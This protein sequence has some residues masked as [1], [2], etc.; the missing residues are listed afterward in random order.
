MHILVNASNLKQ[1]G[2][3][4]VA[5]SICRLLGRFPQ[6]S[7]VA[8]ISNAMQAIRSDLEGLQNVSVKVYDIRNTISSVFFH[9]DT[10]LDTLVEK[11][12]IDAVLTVFGP[13]RWHPSVP[14]LSGFARAQ[15]LP[16]DTPYFDSVTI[17]DRILNFFVKRS[18][19]A[20]SD[21][22]WTEN[23]A[24]SDLLLKV[25]P[26]KRV[27]TVSNNYNQ[28]FDS[29]ER[30]KMRTLPQFRG[31]T[32]LTVTNAYPH[33][34]LTIAVKVAEVLRERYPD[35]NFRFVFTIEREEFPGMDESLSRHFFFLGKVG[36]EECP[37]LY[38][39][40]DIMFQPTLLE[41][42]SATYPEAMR[43]NVPILT[44]DLSFARGLCGDAALYFSPLSADDAADNIYE[45]A[46][47]LD[48]RNRLISS[49]RERLES[50]KNSEQRVDDLISIV[51]SLA[52]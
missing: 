20:C 22:Y 41:S 31:S 8:V 43:M 2:G 14:H 15:I 26:K 5:D 51:E 46:T 39:Q 23:Q 21:C 48:L 19:R 35:F 38:Q 34:N 29:P 52:N 9:R 49:G 13:S 42:F 16:M 33:K 1:G 27:Y 32:L 40:A 28:V 30:W 18:F 4:Q 7:F 6:H 24:V 45:L 17:K 10:Y 44:T 12:H 50:F 11:N 36:I 37:S 47:N 25:F 3:V